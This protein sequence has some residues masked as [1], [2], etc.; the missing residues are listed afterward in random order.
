MLQ[1][2]DTSQQPNDDQRCKTFFG[3]LS[4]ADSTTNIMPSANI[5]VSSTRSLY[6]GPKAGGSASHP[7]EVIRQLAENVRVCLALTRRPAQQ[8]QRVD[9]VIP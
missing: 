1:K 2:N 7:G 3:A 9:V 6:G 4:P 5:L 8:D